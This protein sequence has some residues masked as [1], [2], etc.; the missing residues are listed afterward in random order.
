[1]NI[2][3]LILYNSHYTLMLYTFLYGNVRIIVSVCR[4][5]Q[6]GPSFP[7]I[8]HQLFAVTSHNSQMTSEYI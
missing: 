6:N 7:T 5:S 1:M 3:N 8:T 4:F 2:Y